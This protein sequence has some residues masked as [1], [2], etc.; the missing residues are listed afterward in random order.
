LCSEA[1]PNFVCFIEFLVNCSDC[2]GRN[3]LFSD[4]PHQLL[5]KL[6]LLGD[7][8]EQVLRIVARQSLCWFFHDVD[9]F[10]S[11]T[12]GSFSGSQP[13]LLL[14]QPFL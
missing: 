8:L 12:F 7:I 13:F 14:L 9:D 11:A 6:S 5:E 10:V 4:L 3:G 1:I 2:S